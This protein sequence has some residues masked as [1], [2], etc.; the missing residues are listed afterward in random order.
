[1]VKVSNW[2]QKLTIIALISIVVSPVILMS[3]EYLANGLAD[4]PILQI[5]LLAFWGFGAGSALCILAMVRV[6]DKEK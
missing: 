5:L 1:M 2:K 3:S 4:P 6:M